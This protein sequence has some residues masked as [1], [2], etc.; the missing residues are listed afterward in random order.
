M[1]LTISLFVPLGLPAGVT[2]PALFQVQSSG[3]HRPSRANGHRASH[4][5]NTHIKRHRAVKHRST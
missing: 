1:L 4:R 2:S 3:T 5:R